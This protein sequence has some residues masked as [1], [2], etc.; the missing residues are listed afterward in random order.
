MIDDSMILK[1]SG[2]DARTFLQGQLT[3]DMGVLAE[4]RWTFAAYCSPQGRVLAFLWVF[5]WNDGILLRLPR[6]V[7]NIFLVQIRKY[8]LRSDVVF[9]ETTLCFSVC[10]SGKSTEKQSMIQENE[11]VWIDGIAGIRPFLSENKGTEVL[12]VEAFYAARIRAGIP[13]IYADTS[14]LFLPQML[15]MEAIHGVS[16]SKGCYVGQ[17][18]VAR[19]EYKTRLHRHLAIAET[20]EFSTGQRALYAKDKFA[21]IILDY[22]KDP[23]GGAVIQA[24]IEDRYLDKPLHVRDSEQM[25][26][27]HLQQ[28]SQRKL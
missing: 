15:N 1:V 18:V 9:T 27:F 17:E 10:E 5:P 25:L 21:G 12:P 6:S 22:G 28:K 14:G 8:V 7:S 16:F 24:V 19:N 2:N 20:T 4:G 23:T 11:K 13:E 3:C 26:S